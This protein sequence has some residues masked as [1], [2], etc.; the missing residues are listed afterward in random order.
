MPEI[1]RTSTAKK[2]L[3][4]TSTIRVGADAVDALVNG[5]NDFTLEL[6]HKADALAQAE[7]RTTLMERDISTAMKSAGGID[8]SPE[9]IFRAVEKMTPEEVG[10]IA[11]LI[12]EWVKSNRQ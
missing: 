3:K 12:A 11:L 5:L 1:T 6:V 2:F 7:D 9:G 10:R 8:P 4:E